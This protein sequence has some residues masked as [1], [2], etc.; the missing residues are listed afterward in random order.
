M[1]ATEAEVQALSDELKQLRAEFVRLGQLIE[2]TAR[3]ASTEAAQAARAT[4]ERAWGE[5]R[6]GADELASRIES[7]PITAAATAFGIGIFLGLLF[8]R[9]S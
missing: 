1:S 2:S 5:M 4:G 7:R 3:T 8:G 6:R 9:R